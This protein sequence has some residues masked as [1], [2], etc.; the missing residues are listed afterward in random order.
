LTK[1]SERE[2][3]FPPP[4]EL[5]LTNAVFWQ[6]R[7]ADHVC[8]FACATAS[9]DISVC[10]LTLGLERTFNSFTVLWLKTRETMSKHICVRQLPTAEGS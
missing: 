10:H 8:S 9:D 4:R 3:R 5:C 7:A 1:M 2:K 6:S